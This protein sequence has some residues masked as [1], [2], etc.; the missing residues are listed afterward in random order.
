[1]SVRKELEIDRICIFLSFGRN[2]N[3]IYPSQTLTMVMN[4]F[5]MRTTRGTLADRQ[6]FEPVTGMLGRRERR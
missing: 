5:I 4:N 1:M 6:P 3:Q 2:R